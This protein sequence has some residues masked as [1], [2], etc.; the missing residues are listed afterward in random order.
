MVTKINVLFDWRISLAFDSVGLLPAAAVALPAAAA[1]A[2]W[3]R[4]KAGFLSTTTHAV[5]KERVAGL[6]ECG[7][8][9]ET[10]E[11]TPGSL[12]GAALEEVPEGETTPG[13]LI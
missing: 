2:D 7:E 11:A 6:S 13:S 12:E 4:G 5:E 3:T 8:D 1:A 10:S 9:E